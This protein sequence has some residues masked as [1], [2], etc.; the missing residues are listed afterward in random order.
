MAASSHWTMAL[1]TTRYLTAV[2]GG[3]GFDLPAN[4]SHS[5]ARNARPISCR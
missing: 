2:N 1:L 3:K 4:L 5:A